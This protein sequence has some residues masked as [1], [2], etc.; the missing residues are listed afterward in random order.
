M[1]THGRQS[2]PSG[3]YAL[4]DDGV[5]P[6]LPLE[7]KAARLLAGGARILQLRMKQASP[8]RALQAARAIAGM[9]RAQGA[10]CLVNDRVDL[11]SLSGAGGVHVGQSDL[12]VAEVRRLDASLRVGVS[13]HSI[14]VFGVMALATADGSTIPSRPTGT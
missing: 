12:T 9:C 5:R 4:C 11:A 14:F 10:V 8:G 1:S 3:L 2:L 13:T 7:E 6:E